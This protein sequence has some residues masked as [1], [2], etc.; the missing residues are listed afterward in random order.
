MKKLYILFLITTFLPLS[1]FS[2][3]YSADYFNDIDS[4]K[5]VQFAIAPQLN[6]QLD[7]AAQ[8]DL[9]VHEGEETIA[10]LPLYMDVY[11]PKTDTVSKRPVV[12]MA[13][14]G[15]FLKGERD[16]IE[17]R[18]WC[19]LLAKAGYVTATFDYRL[20]MGADVTW[21]PGISFPISVSIDEVNARRAVYRAVQ[22]GRAAV[23]FIKSM[24]DTYNIDTTRVYMVGSSAGGYIAIHN[25]YYKTLDDLP[26]GIFDAP[27][28]GPLDSI[29]VQGY[30]AVANAYISL[31]GAIA[32]TKLLKNS[33]NPAF[34]VHGTDDETVPFKGGY[35][36]QSSL[37]N[38][39][40][41]SFAIDSSYGSYCMDTAWMR[42]DQVYTT[43]FV[44]GEDHGFYSDDGKTINAYGDTI[45]QMSLKFLW[46]QH[47]PTAGF[48]VSV[49][50]KTAS[51]TSSTSADVQ[52]VTWNF[53]DGSFSAATNPVHTYTEAG[54]YTV[55]QYVMNEI[56]SVDTLAQKVYVE[57]AAGL[58]DVEMAT[59]KVYPNPGAGF[60][61]I[62]TDKAVSHLRLID[63]S[64][65]TVLEKSTLL[66][67]EAM[68]NT[69]LK[70]GMYLLQFEW[71]GQRITQKL[72]VR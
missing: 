45:L 63:L 44:E 68:N 8:Y 58:D 16:D 69:A 40:G 38:I 35:A 31:W 59:V 12:L 65:K 36:L 13:H 32:D 52:S 24:A 61:Y 15:A 53:G 39:N 46:Q 4:I 27:T 22:D 54:I 42:T 2:Q 37:P 1:A 20:G 17:M 30:G 14:S 49:V 34:L 7:L 6:N 70:K 56:E 29:G 50:E 57:V 71:E 47:K 18:T 10:D 3:R 5:N 23:R 48:E 55:T 9:E 19:Y 28:L 25:Q 64:G 60:F 41:I 11:M 21:L 66:S 43:Y 51:F 67:G 72:V 62:N 33:N 26:E